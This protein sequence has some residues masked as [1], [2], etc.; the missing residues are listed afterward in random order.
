VIT[1]DDIRGVHVKY[2]YHCPRQ[3]WLFGRGFR[4]ESSSERVQFGQAVE[5]TSYSRK[6]PVDLGAAR[7]DF[8]DG[9]HW[10][11]EVKSSSRITKADIAQVR[12]YCLRLQHTGI[13][14]RGGILHYPKVRRTHRL[15]YSDAE[16][17]LA[18]ADIIAAL[19]IL[20]QSKS[21][22]RLDRLACHGCSYFD[23]CWSSD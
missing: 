16:A 14:V 13:D 10:V 20:I 18:Y 8:V 7:L 9:Q 23:Y 17:A 22:P 11:H 12:H 2:L 15:D 5:D 19:D 6:A 4:P 1:A 3:L 21:P